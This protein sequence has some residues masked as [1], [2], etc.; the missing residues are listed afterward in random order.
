MSLGLNPSRARK[1]P[2]T[3]IQVQPLRQDLITKITALRSSTAATQLSCGTSLDCEII[4]TA[5]NSSCA[6]LNC[7][8]RA[9]EAQPIAVFNSSD[10]KLTHRRTPPAVRFHSALFPTKAKKFR[11][12]ITPVTLQLPTPSNRYLTASQKKV[13]GASS[14][15]A[16]AGRPRTIHRADEDP[17]SSCTTFSAPAPAESSRPFEN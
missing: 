8:L 13:P 10:C 14:T 17:R 11:S 15:T 9:Q 2:A 3:K 12:S 16:L 1:F 6:S 4:Y 7:Q 5:R